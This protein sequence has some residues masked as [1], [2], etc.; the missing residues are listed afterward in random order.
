VLEL[1][2]GAAARNSSHPGDEI[3]FEDS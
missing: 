1:E 3:K 2:A